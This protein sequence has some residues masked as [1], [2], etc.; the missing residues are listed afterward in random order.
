M[1]TIARD[2]VLLFSGD[3][4]SDFVEVSIQDRVLRAEFSLGDQSKVVRMESERRN[5]VN[6]GEWHTVQLIYYDRVGLCIEKSSG[7]GRA[8]LSIPSACGSVSD[9]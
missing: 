4:D 2:G 7:V 3:R 5:R 1:A 9:S 8:L 6:D